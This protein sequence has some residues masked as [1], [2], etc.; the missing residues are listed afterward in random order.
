[1]GS[2]GYGRSEVAFKRIAA[3]ASPSAPQRTNVYVHRLFLT[4]VLC[5]RM[6]LR[7]KLSLHS[8]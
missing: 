4:D 3:S 2:G 6:R 8:K 7:I 1:M 5:V